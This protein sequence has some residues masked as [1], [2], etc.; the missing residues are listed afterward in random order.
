MKGALNGILVGGLGIA[1]HRFKNAR[2]FCREVVLLADI[3]LQVVQLPT[4]F[5][6]GPDRLPVPHADRDLLAQLPVEI[7]MQ[8]LLPTDRLGS[9]QGG[10]D[11]NAVR[12]AGCL[13][14]RNFS[15]RGHDVGK[16]PEEVAFAS[17]GNLT[18][19]AHDHRDAQAPLV[20]GA[21]G[22]PKFG[23]RLGVDIR[24]MEAAGKSLAPEIV[25][26][27]IVPAKEK[28]GVFIKLEFLQEGHQLPHLVINHAD[29]GRVATGLFRP[30]LVLVERPG[31]ITVRDVKDAMRWGER[32][33]AQEG[34]LFI[35]P[36]EFYRGLID[37]IVRIRLTAAPTLVA[38]ERNFLAVA[39]DIGRI[40]GV[41]MDLVVVSKEDVK[42]VFLRNPGGTPA[43]TTPL[44][45][46]AGGVA[47]AFQNGSNGGFL[48][49]QRRAATV[50]PDRGV[51]AVFS[52]H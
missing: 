39:H 5:G 38:L 51:A 6:R 45:K 48:R 50:Y 43:A 15:Q 18:R 8:F 44:P 28:Q 30:V 34:A 7:F 3:R 24:A 16:V 12:I 19:P 35:L 46:T 20:K 40:V 36:D 25:V 4:A 52:G 1:C 23:P 10:Q 31:G 14:P 27:A 49:P 42:S 29:H 32:Q 21:L 37:H 2:F 41:R 13:N 9:Q 47:P 26:A 33:V 22:A 17:R 11:R